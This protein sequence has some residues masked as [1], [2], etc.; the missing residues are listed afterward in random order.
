MMIRQKIIQNFPVTVEDIEIAEKIFGTYMSTLKGITT[1]KRPKVVVDN[2]NQTPREL[3]DNT[4]ELILCMDIML[5]DQQAYST[6]IDKDIMFHGFF[7]LS[8]IIKEEF[9]RSLDI[10]IRNYNK[11]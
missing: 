8:N 4:Q 1:I 9:H 6:K 11:A 5:I 7:T 3:I 2:F 10:V